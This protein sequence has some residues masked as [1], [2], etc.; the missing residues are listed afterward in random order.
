[1]IHGD[2]KGWVVVFETAEVIAPEDAGAL[3]GGPVPSGK[4]EAYTEQGGMG[5]GVRA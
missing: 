5:R 3:T 1:L 2:G 4:V